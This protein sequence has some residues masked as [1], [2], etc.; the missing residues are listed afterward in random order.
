MGRYCAWCGSAMLGLAQT[1]TQASSAICSGCVEE[2]EP[3]LVGVG[4]QLTSATTTTNG[5]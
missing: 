3:L 1:R 2:L 4:L 5:G